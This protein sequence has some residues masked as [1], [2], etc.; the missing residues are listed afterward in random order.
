[1]KL[2]QK[3]YCGIRHIK[4]QTWTGPVEGFLPTKVIFSN[5]K[6]DTEGFIGVLPSD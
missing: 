3:A 4:D 5:D 6:D 1:M 2:S